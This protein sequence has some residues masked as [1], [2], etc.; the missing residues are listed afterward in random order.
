MNIN[1]I[2]VRGLFDDFNH[3]LVFSPG[4]DIM[5]LVGPNGSGKTT[6]LKL[7]NVLFNQSFHQLCSMPFQEIDVSFDNGTRLVANRVV[8]SHDGDSNRLPLTLIFHQNGTIQKFHPPK[9]LDDPEKLDIPLPAIEDLIPALKQIGRQRWMDLETGFKLDLYDVLTTYSEYFPP[10]FLREFNPIPDW[11]QNIKNSTNVRLIATER[12]TRIFPNDWRRHRRI[13]SPTVRT[14]SHY[15]KQLADRIQESIAQYGTLSQSLDRSFPSRLVDNRER[16]NASIEKLGQDL[17]EI[18]KTRSNLEEAG[19]LQG[20]QPDLQIPDLN[21][22][23]ESQRSVLAVYAKDAKE[24][25]AVF[26]ELYDRVSTFKRIVNSRFNHKQVSVNE[27]DLCINK[28]GN[29]DLDL[30]MLSSGEQHEIVM[31]YEFLFCASSNSLILID[32]PEISLHVAWQEKW[33]EDLEETSKLSNF[34]AIVAT[35]SPEIIADRWHLAVELNGR[36]SN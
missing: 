24:K 9:V 10:R 35:H 21:D 5:L 36:V 28:N 33:L 8:T 6:I 32:E 20:D 30:E 1:Q 15:S 13:M 22:V 23:D 4:S 29:A 14:V 31:L 12:L 7:I 3:D 19:L 27:K 11:L 16:T 34:R 17:D 18:E 2:N 26:D 25:L